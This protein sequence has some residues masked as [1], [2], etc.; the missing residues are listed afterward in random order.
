M[1]KGPTMSD[2][3]ELA[4][5]ERAILARLADIRFARLALAGGMTIT[6]RDLG[7]CGHIVRAYATPKILRRIADRMEQGLADRESVSETPAG[8]LHCGGDR[9][10]ALIPDPTQQ[11][12]S[13]SG[14]SERWV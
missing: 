12:L 11:A 8:Y 3:T 7:R 6:E 13:L 9:A 2:M 10:V 1:G 4:A 5:E 14:Y